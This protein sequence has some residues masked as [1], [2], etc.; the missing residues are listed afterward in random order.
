MEQ[1]LKVTK[2]VFV[3]RLEELISFGDKIIKV[4]HMDV[5]LRWWAGEPNVITMRNHNGIMKYLKWPLLLWY[6]WTLGMCL[7]KDRIDPWLMKLDVSQQ[8]EIAMKKLVEN[9][10]TTNTS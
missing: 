2:F 9:E 10:Q 7:K 3:P 5:F 4:E 6:L 8:D 1:Y